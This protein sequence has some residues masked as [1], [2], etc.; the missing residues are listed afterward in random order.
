M[1]IIFK[2]FCNMLING[3]GY[4]FIRPDDIAT[5]TDAELQGTRTET[6]HFLMCGVSGNGQQAYGI[7]KQ[8][9]VNR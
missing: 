9:S 4:T 1:S 7:I 2:V 3:G 5:M 8:L 6:D